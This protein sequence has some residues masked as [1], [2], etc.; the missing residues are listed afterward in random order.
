[1]AKASISR[2]WD[3][4]R[5]IL[6]R[7]GKLLSAVALAL[8]VLPQVV[9]GVLAP[10]IRGQ[11]TSNAIFGLIAALF[12]LVGQL[13][14]IRLALG[15]S[16]SVG[17]AIA[18]G[19]RRFPMLLIAMLL[20]GL[21]FFVLL[22]PFAIAATMMGVAVPT[23]GGIPDPRLGGMAILIALVLVA[24]SARFVLMTPIT[25]AERVGPLRIIRRSWELTAGNYFRFLGLI[26]LLLVLAAILMSAATLIGGILGRLIDPEMAPLSIGAFIVSL[27]A[28]LAQAVFSVISSVMLARIYVQLAGSGEAQASVPAT[29][30]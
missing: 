3:E 4:T 24:L 20:L 18:H 14:L 11:E 9:A 1:M 27:A 8:I 2:A 21:L 12:G 17:E 26:V 25:S 22:I 23:S 28:G 29:G 6:A 16:V 30:D 7:E 5:M 10:P 13:A 19:V 15:P